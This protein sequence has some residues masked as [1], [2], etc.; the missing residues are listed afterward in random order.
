MPQ[1]V[2]ISSF[3]GVPTEAVV[4]VPK[5]SSKAYSTAD[6]WTQFSDFREM[7]AFDI[8]LSETTLK[9]GVGG[10]AELTVSVTKDDDVTIGDHEWVSSNPEVATVED[11]KV[12]AVAPGSAVITYTIYDGYG[13]AHS[14]TCTV[15][16]TDPSGVQD[17][18]E[19]DVASADVFNLH[20]VRV[21][22][23]ATD[24]D[25]HALPAGIYIIHQGGIAKKI[26]VN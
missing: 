7:G 6:G 8:T 2:G 16:V 15:T 22:R 20:G 1:T 18:A 25:F 5:G 12:G 26:A 24:A 23:N 19:D 13:V 11:G 9:L 21:L 4:Y 14:E 17:I 10:S 3:E